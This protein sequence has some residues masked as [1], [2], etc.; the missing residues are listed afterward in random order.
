MKFFWFVGIFI[1]AALTISAATWT[2]NLSTDWS[3]PGNWSPMG[4]PAGTT[5]VIIPYVASGNYPDIQATPAYCRDLTIQPNASL[6]ISSATLYSN[7]DSY[8]S[9]LLRIT[10]RPE[11]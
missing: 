11:I 4:V 6:T 1:T 2:G 5:D 9:G 8:I 10:S 7:R 3:S